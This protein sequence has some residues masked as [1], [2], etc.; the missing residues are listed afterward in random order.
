MASI[1]EFISYGEFTRLV[2]CLT[3]DIVEYF[4]PFLLTPF[5][6]DI[7]DVVGLVSSLF[8][9]RWIGLFA[10]LEL[11]PGFDPLPINVLTWLIWVLNRRRG[12][13]RY[14]MK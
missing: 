8:M 5:V 12:D 11:V 13:L 4:L 7:F 6:G 9:F 10:L 14:L 1:F 2:V 3:L